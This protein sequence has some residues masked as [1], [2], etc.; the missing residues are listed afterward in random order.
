[1]IEQKRTGQLLASYAALQRSLGANT[2]GAAP[3]NFAVKRLGI[4][5]DVPIDFYCMI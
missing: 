1:L 3:V 4:T 5:F 2:K